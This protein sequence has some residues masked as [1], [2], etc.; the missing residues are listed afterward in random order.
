MYVQWE[1]REGRETVLM[2]PL[3][4]LTRSS[5]MSLPK[6]GPGQVTV[7]VT[8]ADVGEASAGG[9]CRGRGEPAPAVSSSSSPHACSSF[10]CPGLTEVIQKR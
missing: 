1:E 6:Q 4:G 7:P 3:V 2:A 5:Q 9:S 10:A 8:W